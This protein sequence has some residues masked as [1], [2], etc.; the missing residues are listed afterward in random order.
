M[1]FIQEKHTTSMK[2]GHN[3][4]ILSSKI[5]TLIVQVFYFSFSID[6]S[7]LGTVHECDTYICTHLVLITKKVK[8]RKN[9]ENSRTIFE[10]LYTVYCCHVEQVF[11]I[12][13]SPHQNSLT[14]T[15]LLVNM[16]C[17]CVSCFR[18]LDSAVCMRMKYKLGSES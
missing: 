14:R 1:L 17:C 4:L 2:F 9:C 10:K 15:H 5:A 13:T 12:E 3:S 6:S 8:K 16:R 18:L 11:T 7:V